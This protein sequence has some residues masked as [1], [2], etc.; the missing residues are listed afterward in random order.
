MLSVTLL[1]VPMPMPSPKPAVLI[2]NPSADSDDA[3]RISIGENQ[4]GLEQGASLRTGVGFF[5]LAAGGVVLQALN[6]SVC[7]LGGFSGG[8]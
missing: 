1:L 4:I 2:N 5:T 8:R 7:R 6:Q 3:L